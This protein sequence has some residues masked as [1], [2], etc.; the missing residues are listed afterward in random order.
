M[1][2]SKAQ[3]GALGG[4]AAAGS[5]GRERNGRWMG[6]V[7][8][9]ACGEPAAYKSA[10]LCRRCRDRERHT[11]LV[12]GPLEPWRWWWVRLGRPAV[13]VVP[14]C[15]SPHKGIGLCQRHLGREYRNAHPLWIAKW[16]LSA[17]VPVRP[18]AGVWDQDTICADT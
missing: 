10:R 2:L 4:R 6:D 11:G 7:A 16:K 5:H 13:C 12:V 14:T 3:A 9:T 15:S 18:P 17:G 8:C 1:T